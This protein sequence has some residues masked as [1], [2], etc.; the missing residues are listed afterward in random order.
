MLLD[1]RDMRALLG[2]VEMENSRDFVFI[3]F[4]NFFPV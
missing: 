4:L 2:K 1:N 3:S